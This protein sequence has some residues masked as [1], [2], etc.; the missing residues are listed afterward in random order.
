MQITTTMSYHLTLFR[1][2]LIKNLQTI[3]AEKG[4]EKRGHS[5]TVGGNVIDTVTME[6]G[7]EIPSKLRNKTTI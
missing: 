2:A 3:N 5:C 6:D 4:V 1:M 7:M